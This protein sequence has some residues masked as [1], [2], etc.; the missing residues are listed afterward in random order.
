MR[1]VALTFLVKKKR[2]RKKNGSVICSLRQGGK[3]RKKKKNKGGKK[4]NEFVRLFG[5][6]GKEKHP[7]R[8]STGKKNK[9]K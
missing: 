9:R 6:R 7:Q 2:G 8:V 5:G 1:K 3:R 4:R